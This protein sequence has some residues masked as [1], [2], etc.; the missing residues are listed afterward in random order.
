MTQHEHLEAERWW[1]FGVDQQIL[2]IANEMNRIS[3]ALS[4]GRVDVCRRG[5]ERVL[6]LTDLTAGGPLRP[7]LRRELLR[8]RDLPAKLYTQEA[9]EA[10][11]HRAALRAL[12]RLTSTS[13][14]QVALLAAAR[15]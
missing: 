4:S 1:R 11:A 12:L 6:R 10:A 14:K 5:Y 13:S 15:A 3:T 7:S 8:W 2:M 9:P